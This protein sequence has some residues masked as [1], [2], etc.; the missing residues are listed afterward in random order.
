[1]S[2]QS[3]QDV[4]IP[5]SWKMVMSFRKAATLALIL[6]GIASCTFVKTGMSYRVKR[7]F[8]AKQITC[9]HMKCLCV[10]KVNRCSRWKNVDTF[11]QL[12]ITT[13]ENIMTHDLPKG[14]TC[15]R[16]ILTLSDWKAFHIEPYRV[17]NLRLTYDCCR[18]GIYSHYIKKD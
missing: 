3:Y 5:V 11:W 17:V 12:I 9:G 8:T 2:Q 13:F 15:S 16:L 4:H 18:L 14:V 1:M 6:Q 7:L 10:L